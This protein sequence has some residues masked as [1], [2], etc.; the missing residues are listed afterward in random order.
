MS[1]THD[2]AK[3]NVELLSW[4]SLLGRPEAVA[5]VFADDH[6]PGS[7]AADVHA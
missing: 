5:A 6:D 7:A 2:D 3:L 4:G 1:A